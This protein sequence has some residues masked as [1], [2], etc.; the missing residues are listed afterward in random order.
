[1][2]LGRPELHSSEGAQTPGGVRSETVEG[3]CQGRAGPSREQS[4][5]GPRCPEFL[6]A[7][8]HEEPHV[9]LRQWE[10]AREPITSVSK[11]SPSQDRDG[12]QVGSLAPTP[13]IIRTLYDS[14]VG[15]DNSVVFSVSVDTLG[16]IFITPERHL[17]QY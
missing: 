1:M 5:L 12:R 3:L 9:C 6:E 15:V 14:P 16:N 11:L 13:F 2:L 8:H 4:W 10:P 17:L 7:S